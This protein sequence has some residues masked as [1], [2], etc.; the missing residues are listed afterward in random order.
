MGNIVVIAE[1]NMKFSLTKQLISVDIYRNIGIIHF[2]EINFKK[3]N[4]PREENPIKLN[5]G[6]K[7]SICYVDIYEELFFGMKKFHKTF[8]C[9]AKITRN[10]V[11]RKKNLDF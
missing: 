6:E 11:K 7:K 10:R 9:D 3:S 2:C 8:P 4:G 1:I 5:F